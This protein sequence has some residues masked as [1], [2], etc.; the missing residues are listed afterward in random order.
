MEEKNKPKNITPR[1]QMKIKQYFMRG[2]T[3]FLVILAGIVCYFAFLR[4]DDIAGLLGKIGGILQPIIL[5]LVFA[6]LLNPLVTI[7]ENQVIKMF[8]K[9]AKNREKLRKVSRSIGIAGSLL[10]AFAVVILL[11]NMVIPELYR[12]IRDLIMGLPHQ[13]NNAID[14]LESEKIHDT[15][16]SG[17][18]K[19]VLE[20][21][22]EAFQMW[23]KTDLL[24][25]INQMMSFVTVGVFSVVETLFDIAVGVIVSVYVLNS[26]E[27]FTGQCK[28]ITY[29]LLSRERANL[30]LQITRKSHKI[31]GGFVIGKII[32][33]III[34]IL[35]FIGLSILDIPYT[36][37]V[38]VIVGVT[39]V[40]PFFGPYIGAI[41]SAILILLSEPIKGIYFVIFIL[42]LQQFDGN[43]LGPKILGDSTGLSAFWVVFSILL[44]GGLFGFVG[45]I[46]GVPTFAV[47]YYLVSMFIEQKLERK[48]LP[49]ESKE[50]EEIQYIEEKKEEE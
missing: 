40:V 19:S 26:K 20:N 35:C 2:L 50:Y 46:M 36:L 12:S 25:R 11:L 30:M 33:S 45:M 39:N 34:G 32:D 47:F 22:A 24:T 16:F 41:P 9:K 13:I 21:G 29:A 3:S 6:Y 23:L 7:I 48:K 44:G 27:K 49:K 8:E 15:A 5:G 42:V 4:L 37:L 1:T 17:T 10:V 14:F 43:I 38:S 31:F 28:K 18:I